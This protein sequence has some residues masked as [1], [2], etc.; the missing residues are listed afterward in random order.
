MPK[1]PHAAIVAPAGSWLEAQATA[2]VAEAEQLG[3][4]APRLDV[5]GTDVVLY[6]P[7]L[8]PAPGKA[9]AIPVVARPELGGETPALHGARAALAAVDVLGHAAERIAVG[10]GP[11]PAK[12]SAELEIKQDMLERNLA[13]MIAGT[14]SGDHETK[15]LLSSYGVPVTRQVVATTPSAAV[16]GARRVAYPVEIKPWGPDA[17]TEP[18]GCPVERAITSDAMVRRA[19]AAVLAASGKNGEG[20]VIVREVPPLGRDVHVAFHNLPHLGWTVVLDAPGAPQIAAA[21]APLRLLD[22]QRLAAAIVATRAGDPEPDR[23]GLANLLRRASHLVVDLGDRLSK[24]ELPRV[25]VG[26]R[27]SRSVVVDAWCELTK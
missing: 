22:A 9:L 6:D 7:E 11:A 15:L 16:N 12:A 21:P 4:R 18:Q 20:A 5:A 1:G 24:L 19:Y 26:G 3:T 13:K 17:P 14:R 27:G 25:V 2:L 23:A 10:L 8:A